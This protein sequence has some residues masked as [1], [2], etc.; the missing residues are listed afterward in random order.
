MS[1]TFIKKNYVCTSCNKAG[2]ELFAINTTLDIKSCYLE[3]KHPKLLDDTKIYVEV[4]ERDDFGLIKNR[5]VVEKVCDYCGSSLQAEKKDNESPVLNFYPK[6]E[7]QKWA[8]G[9]AKVGL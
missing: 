2:Y 8:D 3:D 1:I 7:A 9:F 6:T 5:Y 4:L